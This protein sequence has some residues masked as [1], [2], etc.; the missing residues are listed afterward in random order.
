[1]VVAAATPVVVATG[2]TNAGKT[3]AVQ[4]AAERS[5]GNGYRVVGF[6]QPGRFA[7][8]EK[9]GF[10]V[11]DLSTGEETELA[12]SVSRDQGEH[13]TRFRFSAAGFALAEH[14]LSKARSGDLLVVDE[15]GP[16][17]L[18]GQGHMPSVQ[19]ALRV[20]GLAAVVLVVR[21]Q[22]VPAL[23]AAL[24]VENA[25][26]VDTTAPGGVQA[27]LSAIEQARDPRL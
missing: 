24:R 14:A 26:V 21:I 5:R 25:V 15:L 11:R 18:R 17:E 16:L 9:V 20:P 3:T 12:R 19:R 22:L 4:A 10:A 13:G 6:V 8:G 23:L 27:L 2:A 7:D 1:V